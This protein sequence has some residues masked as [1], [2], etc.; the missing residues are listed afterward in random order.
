MK[1]LSI[2]GEVTYFSLLRPTKIA[3][4]KGNLNT[5]IFQWLRNNADSP[6]RIIE[7]KQSLVL[8][9]DQNSDRKLDFKN[10]NEMLKIALVS[11]KSWTNL[12]ANISSFFFRVNSQHIAVLINDEELRFQSDRIDKY[13]EMKYTGEGNGCAVPEGHEKTICKIGQGKDT[14]IF[15]TVSS[16][17]F[18]CRKFNTW[19][20]RYMLGRLD[21][22]DTNA[23][24]IGDCRIVGRIN[25]TEN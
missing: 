5:S 7:T 6:V 4:W 14:C 19:M 13:P 21:K 24:R 11:D 1:E 15:L 18:E 25:K 20:A 23:G 9:I 3:G 2:T 22:G 8:K 16:N 10:T 12:V 17:G